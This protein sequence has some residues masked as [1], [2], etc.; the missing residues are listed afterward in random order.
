[1]SV[2]ILEK[3]LAEVGSFAYGRK[4]A[5]MQPAR[6][7][8]VEGLDVLAGAIAFVPGQRESRIT[9]VEIAHQRIARRLGENGRGADG[10][11]AG[12]PF[13]HSLE[14]AFE[15]EPVATW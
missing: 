15:A 9:K 1:M 14:Q 5:S 7:Q 11:N 12:V 8:H 10:R 4:T 3:Q 13:D 6:A 2:S